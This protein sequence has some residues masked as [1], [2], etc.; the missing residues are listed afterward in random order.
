MF[1]RILV[2]LLLA[3]FISLILLAVQS[4]RAPRVYACTG[5]YPPLHESAKQAGAV[6]IARAVTVGSS[7][8]E[9]PHQSPT[10]ATSAT[11]AV[12]P[13]STP[14]ADPTASAGQAGRQTRN[15]EALVGLGAHVD[16]HQV[17]TGTIED[18]FDLD[19]SERKRAEEQVRALETNP[20]FVQPCP[21]GFLV[22]R[23]EAGKD[24]LL[25]LTRDGDGWTNIN[26][27]FEIR[28]GRIDIEYVV[29]TGEMRDLF[30]SGLPAN[31]W[32]FDDGS[33]SQWVI[34]G[35]SV[36]LQAFADAVW[37]ARGELASPARGPAP[38]SITPP[39]TGSAGLRRLQSPR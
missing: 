16:V 32:T 2:L 27:A 13:T 12:T 39:D 1:Y 33:P 22:P 37:F 17:L 18:S 3:P 36:S 4:S 5:A 14:T 25:L 21:V 30:F 10:P 7:E 24:Y 19:V 23:Y 29:V 6:V 26:D 11:L 20:S 35:G 31:E 28:D 15:R 8:F 34:T 38:A 9:F